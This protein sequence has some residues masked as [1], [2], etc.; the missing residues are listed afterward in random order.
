MAPCRCN[1]CQAQ[2][3]S[4]LQ[5]HRIFPLHLQLH[6][7]WLSAPKRPL[8]ADAKLSY[9]AKPTLMMNFCLHPFLTP[10]PKPVSP[11]SLLASALAASHLARIEGTDE[12][13]ALAQLQT[14][15]PERTPP[16][17]PALLTTQLAQS[18][19]QAEFQA[20]PPSP[21]SSPPTAPPPEEEPQRVPASLPPSPPWSEAIST[22]P[23]RIICQKCCNRSYL[24]RWY[25]HGYMCHSRESKNRP[26]LCDCVYLCTYECYV[27]KS[28]KCSI[29]TCTVCI[30]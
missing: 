14:I 7:C 8:G 10:S 12:S 6:R 4:L 26:I 21:P 5:H 22:D 1:L 27:W 25:T 15:T 11:A 20:R 9:Y 13:P 2:L 23:D 28:Y 3:T 16:M 29:S 17:V 24:F 30:I 18:I 19:L